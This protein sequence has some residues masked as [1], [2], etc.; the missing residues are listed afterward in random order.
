MQGALLRS[1]TRR[2]PLA[3][4]LWP[5]SLVFRTLVALRRQLYQ[6]GWLHSQRVDAM[7]I[8]V[9]NVVAG[10]AG[11]TPT[12]ISLVL[13]LQAQGLQVGVISRGY[14]RSSQECLEVLP[15]ALPQDV[16]DEPLLVQRTTGAP[17]FV[18]RTRHAA[19]T[20]LLARHPKTQILV[21]DDG[22]QHYAFYRDL[23]VCVFDDRGTGNGFVLPAGP[24]REPW[25]RTQVASVGQADNRL[26]ML[27]TG[28]HPAFAGYTAQRRLAPYAVRRDGSTVPW[29]ALQT[30]DAKPLL[31]LAGIAQPESFFAMLRAGGLTLAHTLA[32]PDHYDFDSLP[33]SIHEGYQLICTEKDAMKLWQHV[34]DALAIP[35]VQTM[36]AAFFT[37]LDDAVA[38][39]LTPK[40]S[41][42]HGHTTS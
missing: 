15:G 2:G 14:G 33:R 40:L 24:L 1:W 32:L 10:G 6:R 5:V 3:W 12:V 27:H 37:A 13:H 8:V 21:C 35:L 9:G 30:A 34:P 42:P 19:A 16:G 31:A 36:D 41:S 38:T 29:S 26:L 7:V 22:L 28:S 4:A 17:V 23:E 25:P 20:A 18:A 11:K 39:H